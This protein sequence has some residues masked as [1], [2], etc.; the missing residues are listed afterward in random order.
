MALDY[1]LD[2]LIDPESLEILRAAQMKIT[3]AKPVGGETP[4][5]TWLVF[6]PFQGNTVK[7]TET[8]GMYASPTLMDQNGAVIRRM[9]EIFPANDAA[10]YSFDTSA[11]F[12][13]PFT[14]PGSPGPGTFKVDNDMPVNQYP[15]LTFG[16][17]QSATLN[18]GPIKPSPLN[19]ALVPAAIS[20]SFT[21]ITTVYVWLQGQFQSGSVLTEINGD[22]TVVEY[23]GET[24][25]QSLKYQKETGKFIPADSTGNEIPWEDAPHVSFYQRPGIYSIEPKS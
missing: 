17:M 16:L 6:D 14:G 15:F 18:G 9:S 1:T 5:V 19:A 10:Y 21:P 4:N 3:V 13:G 25:N 7:W 23:S 2:L 24:K 11:T 20:A 12:K 8:F 22:A